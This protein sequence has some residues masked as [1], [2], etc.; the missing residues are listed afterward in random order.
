MVSD[1]F[2]EF[3]APFISKVKIQGAADEFRNKYWS[4]ND[5]PIDIEHIIEI[6]LGIQIISVKNLLNEI[7]IDAFI[8]HDFRFITH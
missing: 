1:G 8:S 3:K 2:S 6:D 7:G 5:L 4:D